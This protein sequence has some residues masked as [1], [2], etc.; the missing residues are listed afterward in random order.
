MTQTTNRPLRDGRPALSPGQFVAHFPSQCVEAR[1][2]IFVARC[3]VDTL[4]AAVAA[5]NEPVTRLILAEARDG[6]A[7]MPG[8]GAASSW[9]SLD[10]FG[11]E[12][13]ALANGVVAH[14]FDLDD[15]TDA[16][17]GHVS[18]VLLPALIAMAEARDLS[19]A[20]LVDAYVLGFEVACRLGQLVFKS[21]YAKGWHSTS[22]IGAVAGAAAG[23]RLIGLGEVAADHAISLAVAQAG[24][25]RANFGTMG[26]PFQAGHAA[27]TAVQSVRLASRGFTGGADALTG[28]YGFTRLYAAGEADPALFALPAAGDTLAVDTVGVNVKKYPMCY[29]AHRAVDAMLALRQEHALRPE[30]VAAIDVESSAAGHGPLVHHK[31]QT[32]NEAMFSMEYGM[33]AALVDGRMGCTSFTDAALARAP[34]TQLMTRVTLREVDGPIMPPWSR[35]RVTTTNG[36]VI[37]RRVDT[38]LGSREQPLG[39][40]DLLAKLGDCL[41]YAGRGG[42]AQQLIDVVMS[43]PT[44]SIRA[45]RA[46]SAWQ[47]M[48]GAA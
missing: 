16:V 44:T 18:S 47:E 4:A 11:E 45:L 23:A 6:A 35:V 38:V 32:P 20:A 31:P 43:L 10:M 9:I 26:K 27:R 29:A 46:S 30:Q 36:H 39:D 48:I 1:H 42:D 37:E 40:A 28:P 24:G 34:I 33:A 8:P 22:A 25:T 13:A 14:A 12:A 19:G 15:V 5:A 21:H 2:G 7:R 3:L 41:A 17:R